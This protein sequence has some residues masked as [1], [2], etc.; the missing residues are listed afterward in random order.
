M[1]ADEPDAV[2]PPADDAGFPAI[3]EDQFARLL[4]VTEAVE[5]DAGHVLYRAGDAGYD[6]FV[7]G[8]GQVEVV[9]EEA[10]GVPTEVL[11]TLGPGQFLGELNLLT[12]Q[13]AYLTAR[14]ASAARLYRMSRQDFRRLMAEDA[15]LSDVILGAFMARRENLRRGPAAKSV[16][17]LGEE[18]SAA[19]LAL[20]NWAARL[21][22]PHR[23]VD[24]E[25]DEGHTLRDLLSAGTEDLP[26]VVTPTQ[27][28]RQATPGRLANELGL[29]YRPVP[30]KVFDLVVVGGGPAGLAAALY[31]AS[32][33]L[34]TI[35]VEATSVGGQAGASSRIENYLGFPRGISGG[36]LTA[37]A[38][39][40]AVKFG[41]LVNSPCEACALTMGDG[42]LVVKLSSGEEVPAHAVVVASGARYGKLPLERWTEF[43]GAGI[44]YAATELEARA[45]RGSE[46]VVVGGANSAGQAALFL[47]GKG[48]LVR[49]VVRGDDLSKKMSR[50]LVDRVVPHSRIDVRLSSEVVG[51]NGGDRLESVAV[52]DR[53][54]GAVDD[55]GCQGLFCF[56]GAVPS[57]AWL[58][59]VERDDAGFVF[60][61]NGLP[62]GAARH[63]FDLLGRPPFPFESSVPG[64][65]AAGDVRRGSMKRVAAAVGEGA[66]AVSWVHQAV[67]K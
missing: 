3:T 42:Q 41:A 55:V 18:M 50:Y 26:V 66:S 29:V 16:E 28:L 19:T 5:F 51:L 21:K 39:L 23:W 12:G 22:L 1:S 33:G 52:A 32:E 4:R 59:D 60:T 62:E 38:W 48:S 24:A 54:T 67:G 34:D 17:I 53:S 20:R 40:Q 6:F 9:L 14:T 61:G 2:D 36:D 46:V 27:I 56:I 31:G 37:K 49:L 15:E 64:V 11:V 63:R 43:E 10:P 65:F 25:S 45:C 13:V 30:G 47:A 58:N 8:S 35:L 57:T 44:Y 7:V